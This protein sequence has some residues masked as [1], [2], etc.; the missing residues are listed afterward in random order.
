MVWKWVAKKEIYLHS[1]Q[2]ENKKKF[3][4]GS[5][6]KPV[7]SLD[8]E[9]R[10]TNAILDKRSSHETI[11]YT[12]ITVLALSCINLF[13]RNLRY[14]KGWF[15]GF[16]RRNHLSYRRITGSVVRPSLIGSNNPMMIESI[17]SSFKRE[18]DLIIPSIV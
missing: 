2:A 3:K 9:T 13:D 5:G 17:I 8:E 11:R 4:L 15:Q 7:L 1:L 14:S 18:I 10:L 16:V 12:D 6:R